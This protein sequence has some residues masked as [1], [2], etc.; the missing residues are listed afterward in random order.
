MLIC[1]QC[2]AAANPLWVN[3]KNGKKRLC[4]PCFNANMRAQR[5]SDAKKPHLVKANRAR[6]NKRW[7]V[8]RHDAIMAYGGYECVCCGEDEPMFLT[9]DHIF[10]DGAKHRQN[11]QVRGSGIYQ[12]M[13]RHSYPPGFQILCMNCNMGKQRNGG[14][15]PHNAARSRP[16]L[17]LVAS[18]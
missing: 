12:W 13:K 7:Q 18:G 5:R 15:C 6:C 11:D 3:T 17:T 9:L 14:T 4:Q 8:L 1:R 10:N 2:G 16:T